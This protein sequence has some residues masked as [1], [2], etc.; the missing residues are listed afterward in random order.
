MYVLWFTCVPAAR[1]R[2]ACGRGRPNPSSVSGTCPQRKPSK[3]LMMCSILVT[4]TQHHLR[5]SRLERWDNLLDT[6]IMFE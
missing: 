4:E 2:H 1:D 3:L 6:I 5:E